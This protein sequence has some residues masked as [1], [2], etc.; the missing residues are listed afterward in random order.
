[1]ACSNLI[2][3]LSLIAPDCVAH[4]FLRDIAK[5]EAIKDRILI[6]LSVLDSSAVDR[7]FDDPVGYKK[8]DYKISICCFSA[9][10]AALRSKSKDLMVKN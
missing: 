9:K 6:R 1:M 8:A 7:E 4:S 10:H 2:K 3:I 5:L